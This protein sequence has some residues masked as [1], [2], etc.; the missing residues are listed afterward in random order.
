MLKHDD[1]G[2]EKRRFFMFDV[3]VEVGVALVKIMDTNSRKISDG[4]S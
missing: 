3:D 4:V 2:L 1:V